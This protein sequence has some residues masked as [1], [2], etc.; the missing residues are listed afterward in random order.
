[1]STPGKSRPTLGFLVFYV[2]F[3]VSFTMTFMIGLYLSHQA[4]PQ[5]MDCRQEVGQH[6]SKPLCLAAVCVGPW[7][8]H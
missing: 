6:R 8:V 1:M 2:F 5:S 4:A 3:C 7:N